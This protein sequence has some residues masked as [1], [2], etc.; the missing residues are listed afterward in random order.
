MEKIKTTTKSYDYVIVGAGTSAMGLIYGLLSPYQSNSSQ[1]PF[2]IAVIERGSGPPHAPAT[3]SPRLWFTASHQSS[4][5]SAS[6]RLLSSVLPH[7]QRVMDVPTG[8][9]LGGTTNIHACLCTPPS[10]DDFVTWPN[11]WRNDMMESVHH[12]QDILQSHGALQHYNCHHANVSSNVIRPSDED[13]LP[14]RETCFPSLITNIPLTAVI[15]NKKKHTKQQQQAKNREMERINYHEALVD[16]LLQACPHLQQH[17][18]WYSGIQ[19]ERL[20]WDE[21]QQHC[22]VTGVECSPSL[23]RTAKESVIFFLLHA[24][25]QVIV[26]AGAVETPALLWISGIGPLDELTKAGIQVRQ[27]LSG[28]GRNLCDH[29]MI[30]RAMFT[31]RCSFMSSFKSSSSLSINGVVALA[32]TRIGSHRYQLLVMDATSYA[33]VVPHLVAGYVRRH[34]C[35]T[36]ERCKYLER[37]CNSMSQWLFG[38]IRFLLWWMIASTPVYFLL[39]YFVVATNVVLFNPASRGHVAVMRKETASRPTIIMDDTHGKI[40]LRRRDVNVQVHLN[41]LAESCDIDSLLEGWQELT[42]NVCQKWFPNGIELFPGMLYRGVSSVLW[43]PRTRDS[44]I[45]WFPQFANDFCLPYFHWCGTCAMVTET[46]TT[47]NYSNNAAVVDSRLRV[48]QVPSLCVCDA[49]VFPTTISGPTALTCAALGLRFAKL[50]L[51]EEEEEVKL[52]GSSKKID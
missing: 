3:K 45:S 31:T 7:G 24:T 51:E 2:S 48:L 33:T 11:P 19:V 18:H 46:T 17:V 13:K 39:R 26:C 52:L 25:K 34:V 12:I 47:N 50:L 36:T 43:P 4:S 38:M 14:W 1:P 15:R 41:Y 44:N 28:V 16:P 35:F 20:L 32:H 29:I 23:P 8:Q 49:S 27:S 30:P 21:Q 22:V 10:S 5:S 6:V 9:G 37:L 42:N 40:P